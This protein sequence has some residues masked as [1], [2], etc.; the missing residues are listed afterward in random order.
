MDSADKKHW[1]QKKTFGLALGI[2][3]Q[4]L[5]LVSGIPPWG[6]ILING[7]SLIAGAI[8]IYGFT[9]IERSRAASAKAL[10]DK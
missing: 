7:A 6:G 9:E 5:N 1:W 10:A 2:A 4:A 8:G 3:L